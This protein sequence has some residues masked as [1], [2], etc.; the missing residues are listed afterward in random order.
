[1]T[2]TQ[3]TVAISLLLL[4]ASFFWYLAIKM[5]APQQLLSERQP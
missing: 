2:K 1:M 5:K 4:G 3:D